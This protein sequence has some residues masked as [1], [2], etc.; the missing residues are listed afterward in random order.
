MI[1]RAGEGTGTVAILAGGM[2]TRLRE[3]SGVLPK[4]MMPIAGKPVL[5]HLVAL[6]AAHGFDRIVLLVHHGH[7]LIRDHFGDG[8]AWGVSI[9]YSVED[10]PRGTAGAL[11]DA[12]PMLA[13]QFLLLYG[14]TFADVDLGRL[15]RAHQERSPA[16]TLFLHPNDHPEDSDIVELSADGRATAIHG[17]PHVNGLPAPNLVNAALYVMERAPLADLIPADHS[18]DVAKHLL[19]AMIGAG[20]DVRGYVSP[21]YI[22]DMGTPERLDKVAGDIASGL[23]ERLSDRTPRSAIFLDRDGT[24]NQPRGHISDPDQIALIPGAAAAVRAI[25]RAGRLAVCI[26]NQPVLARGEASWEDMTRIL[27]RIDAQLGAAHAYLDRV[28][29]CPH[30]PD[31]GFA[32]EVAALKVACDCRKPGTGLFDAAIAELN[33]AR[34]TSWMIGDS[35]ADILAGTRAGLRTILVRT[36]EGGKDGKYPCTPDHVVAD[37]GEAVALIL[38]HDR[39]SASACKGTTP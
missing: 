25:N 11:R 30:H 23:V 29:L 36:G 20:L 33:I 3:R 34:D 18:T 13:G 16:A 31:R 28:Y 17:Y 4:P 8:S 27:A 19:P 32:G 15:W 37:V 39:V 35:T 10:Q 38:A 6:C 14:D 24:L 22:K 12:L 26:T 5:E 1:D 9:R 21:E 2:G 7:E